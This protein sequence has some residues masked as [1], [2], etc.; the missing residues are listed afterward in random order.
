[1][2]PEENVGAESK[3]PVALV[4]DRPPTEELP[5]LGSEEPGAESQPEPGA[6]PRKRR[7]RKPKA[8]PTE[9]AAPA[10]DP[11]ELAQL[12]QSSRAFWSV[13]LW[14]LAKARGP[15]WAAA[16]PE[17]LNLLADAWAEGLITWLPAWLRSASP[18]MAAV[19]ATVG[20]AWPR[21]QVD[22]EAAGKDPNRAPNPP[23]ADIGAEV[24]EPKK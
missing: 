21:V 2:K 18:L 20:F 4:T 5:P 8:K 11:A 9:A 24:V 16:N 7:G 12:K 13:L 15:H 1:M 10:V 3:P 6:A 14:F 23:D 17:E 22:L 19:T